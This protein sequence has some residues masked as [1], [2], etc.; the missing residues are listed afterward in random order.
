MKLPSCRNLEKEFISSIPSTSS[1]VPTILPSHNKKYRQQTL[2][3]AF[4]PKKITIT[5]P[6]KPAM[7]QPSTSQK[8]NA[9][10]WE[11]VKK[12]LR[13]PSF[14]KTIV[15]NAIMAYAANGPKKRGRALQR[16]QTPENTHIIS[17]NPYFAEEIKAKENAKAKAPVSQYGYPLTPPRYWD[18]NFPTIEEQQE[19]GM[20]KQS[21]SPLFKKNK[22]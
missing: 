15:K 18:I 5:Q 22:K 10:K 13:S 14:K 17:S 11:E 6:E 16:C 19:R 9:E 1:S 3:D 8:S 7:S 2:T 4:K 21:D 20:I 12:R